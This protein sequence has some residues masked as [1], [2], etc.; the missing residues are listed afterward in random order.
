MERLLALYRD[1]AVDY[2]QQQIEERMVAR[3]NSEEQLR[4]ALGG[5]FAFE[6]VVLFGKNAERGGEMW[7]NYFGGFK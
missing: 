3:A 6:A 7:T 2:F 5:E 4:Q 1:A